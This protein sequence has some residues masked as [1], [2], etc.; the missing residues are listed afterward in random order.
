MAMSAELEGA[1]RSFATAER[2]IVAAGQ[3]KDGDNAMELVRLRRDLVLQFAKLGNALEQDPHL[4]ANPDKM[5]EG[6]RLFAAFR[7]ANSINQA[8]WPAIRVRDE[9]E[10]YRS[11]S[12]P[13][14]ERSRAFWAWVDRELGYRR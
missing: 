6:T 2:D 7:S 14:V 12:L 10:A 9:R 1:L 11:A 13:V 4:K 3:R 5:T 8:N